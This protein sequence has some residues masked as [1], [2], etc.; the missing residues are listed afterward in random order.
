MATWIPTGF[1]T[2]P[3]G[4]SSA[5]SPQLL[6]GGQFAWGFDVAVRGGKPHTRPP[7]V[8]LSCGLPQ[9]LHQCTSYFGVQGGMIVTMIG[10]RLYR[11]RIGANIY[12][13]EPIPLSF[14][15]SPI[16]KQAWMQQTVESLII[17]DGQSDPIIY[18]GGTA[19][20]ATSDEVPRGRMMAYGNGRLWVA[21]NLRELVAGD[22]RTRD[23]GSELKFTETNYLSGGGSLYFSRGI[24]G[25]DFIP[26][27]GAADFGTL[28]VFGPD[29][30]ESIRADVTSRDS[31]AQM[32]GFVTN[33]FRDIGASGDWGIAQVNQ[34][35]YWRDS[36]GNIRSLQNSIST[37]NSPG[38]TPISREVSRIVAY[39]SEKLLPW[40]SSVYFDNRLLMTASPYLNV[41]GGISFKDIVSLD[42]APIST[43]QMKAPPAYDGQW[44]GLPGV[45]QLVTGDFNGMNRA[46]AIT[47]DEEGINRIWEMLPEGRGRDDI[48]LS[49]GSG[50]ETISP[51]KCFVEYPSIN[52]GT[53][54]RRK[55]LERCDVWLSGLEAEFNMT[56]YWRTDNTQKWTKWDEVAVCAK[57][58]DAATST[59]HTWKNL[60]PEQRPQI[61]TFTIPDG[62]DEVTRYGLQIGFQFQIRLEWTGKAQV[63]KMALYGTELPDPDYAFREALSPLCIENDVTG[64]EISYSIPTASGYVFVTPPDPFN[65]SGGL[66]GP[67]SP[68]SAVYNI[69]NLSATA[70]NWSATPS[71]SWLEVDNP[72][73]VIEPGQS[74]D[75]T[76]TLNADLLDSGDYSGSVSFS[77]LT[78]MCGNTVIQVELAVSSEF[79]GE[80]ISFRQYDGP[81]V[82]PMCM[83]AFGDRYYKTESA[84]GD[85]FIK[86]VPIAGSILTKDCTPY[87]PAGSW[88]IVS[89]TWSGSSTI[90]MDCNVTGDLQVILQRDGAMGAYDFQSVPGTFL[91]LTGGSVNS[92]FA[93]LFDPAK[94]NQRA[95]FFASVYSQYLNPDENGVI[96]AWTT[97][98]AP[99]GYFA[100]QFGAGYD[101]GNCQG[102]SMYAELT[103]PVTLADL[104]KPIS[105]SGTYGSPAWTQT[106]H[107]FNG[108]TRTYV[109]Q[110]TQAIF[111]VPVDESRDSL[112]GEFT[113][114]VVPDVGDPYELFIAQDYEITSSTVNG[115]VEYPFVADAVITLTHW[116]YT[117]QKSVFENWSS[118]APYEY[119]FMDSSSSWHYPI[120]FIAPPPNTDCWDDL[121][122]YPD[123]A[124]TQITNNP[125]GYRW[126]GPA[127]FISVDYTDAYD[128]FESYPVGY[129][130]SY[131]GGVGWNSAGGSAVVFYTDAYDDFESYAVGTITTIGFKDFNNLWAGAGSLLEANYGN[132][133]DD[134]E[135]YSTGTIT[136]LNYTSTNNLWNGNG[137]I[138]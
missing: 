87:P 116:M 10:G 52:F 89:T 19:R 27:T 93:Q 15:N 90:D 83:T 94:P 82:Y 78:N 20:R 121:T 131:A 28:M 72:G 126:N 132:A 81:F 59:P 58:T 41:S 67:F 35:L 62:I 14:V 137:R 88:G 5:V 128:D 99:S 103:N 75:V 118:Y 127:T 18:N 80:T 43:M 68:S 16:I 125:Y 74:I 54:N 2:C 3:G 57:V 108:T 101:S 63:E 95:A 107:A 84:T 36:H 50:L 65:V 32:A 71:D 6:P 26:V 37:Q 138:I 7:F 45:A 113:F 64:N 30:A 129:I 34:D 4:V 112:T 123:N 135:S 114:T 53:E 48:S 33:V 70:Y 47:S 98:T 66:G 111:M 110:K 49:C 97:P 136:V 134:F 1:S 60:L 39:D 69:R 117:Y 24:T 44:T 42:F 73:G 46:F 38:S 124:P 25:L 105:R 40:V 104:G 119:W 51:I 130:F 100:G 55:R 12:S 96:R 17:Q 120:T 8:E 22:I 29:Y 102:H 23:P 61:K 122:T 21:I 91:T 31:W 106:T 86:Y 9:G 13:W 92:L 85:N 11:V 109:G 79:P 76:V 133:W 115:M 56:A 77:N